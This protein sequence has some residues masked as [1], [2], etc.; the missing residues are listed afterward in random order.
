MIFKAKDGT[1]LSK[2]ILALLID[3]SERL[4]KEVCLTLVADREG[5]NAEEID[6]AAHGLGA[7]Q[8]CN[9]S[10]HLDQLLHLMGSGLQFECHYGDFDPNRD[11]DPF[12][13]AGMFAGFPREM[14]PDKE[15]IIEGMPVRYTFWLSAQIYSRQATLVVATRENLEQIDLEKPGLYP[16]FEQ[17]KSLADCLDGDGR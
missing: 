7:M 16:T 11:G 5:Y 1:D 14:V 10:T 15:L 12:S 3:R 13:S 2:K 6:S 17:Q 8:S 4:T 9:C